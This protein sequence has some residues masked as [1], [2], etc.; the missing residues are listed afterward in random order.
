MAEAQVMNLATAML[1]LLLLISLRVADE[2]A[3]AAA[4]GTAALLF[5]TTHQQ[6]WPPA[7]APFCTRYSSSYV[8]LINADDCS[9]SCTA[10]CEVR[11][12]VCR[13]PWRVLDHRMSQSKFKLLG[14]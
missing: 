4:A 5:V 12:A 10:S 13:E 2:D 14:L 8:I 6:P 7:E 9:T 1:L 11:E 3:T